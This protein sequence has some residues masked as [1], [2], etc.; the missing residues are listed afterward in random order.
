MFQGG[1]S[2]QVLKVQGLCVRVKN[3]TFEL[4]ENTHLE[5]I[6]VIWWT[7][8]F[9]KWNQK[10]HQHTTCSSDSW[11]RRACGRLE[12]TQLRGAGSGEPTVVKSSVPETGP[13]FSWAE[14]E[15]AS[16]RQWTS[17]T[18]WHYKCVFQSTTVS[19]KSSFLKGFK[20][21]CLMIQFRL[22]LFFLYSQ[23]LAAGKSWRKPQWAAKDTIFPLLEKENK[24][25]ITTTTQKAKIIAFLLPARNMNENGNH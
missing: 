23:V 6:S 22:N 19:K 12:Q 16:V 15:S 1:N 11:E 18:M 2:F 20:Y 9:K 14:H 13:I 8:F 10:G 25:W 17:C 4:L 7:D 24:P 21:C 5:Q 3:I